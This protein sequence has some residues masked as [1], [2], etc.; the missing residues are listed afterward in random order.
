MCLTNAIPSFWVCIQRCACKAFMGFSVKERDTWQCQIKYLIGTRTLRKICSI[1]N[2][3]K[4]KTIN[5]KSFLSVNVSLGNTEIP[6]VLGQE[7]HSCPGAGGTFGI[8]DGTPPP[9]ITLRKGTL[10]PDEPSGYCSQ[11]FIWTTSKQCQSRSAK[12]RLPNFLPL[13]GKLVKSQR[14]FCVLLKVHLGC[15]PSLTKKRF[16]PASSLREKPKALLVWTPCWIAE[17]WFEF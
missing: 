7:A 15:H 4:R 13:A 16:H 1:L 11:K 8:T 3:Q 17:S 10:E 9:E 14:Y 6:Q 2:S 12:R 5:L